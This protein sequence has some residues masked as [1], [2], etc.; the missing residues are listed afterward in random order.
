MTAT[1]IYAKVWT[2]SPALLKA[3]RTIPIKDIP[4][5]VDDSTGVDAWAMGF[6]ECLTCGPRVESH[7]DWIETFGLVCISG[8]GTFILGE[9]DGTGWGQTHKEWNV[10][11]G[12]CLQFWGLAPHSFIS[13]NKTN[14]FLAVKVNREKLAFMAKKEFEAKALELIKNR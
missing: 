14:T 6:A 10:S 3:I 8:G 2:A 13:E 4:K 11:E 7:T 1:S 5:H 9:P 12:S